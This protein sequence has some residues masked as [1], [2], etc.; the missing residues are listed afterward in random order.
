MTSTE[1]I[2]IAI[3]LIVFFCRYNTPEFTFHM[4]KTFWESLPSCWNVEHNGATR[5][6]D[7]TSLAVG[8]VY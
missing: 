7:K 1:R 6:F 5:A 3:L 8:L 4:R 2:Q